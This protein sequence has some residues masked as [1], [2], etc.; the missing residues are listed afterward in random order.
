MA[1]LITTA[2]AKQAIRAA[3]YDTAD[4]AQIAS[5][6]SAVSDWIERHC[7]RQFNDADHV[8]FVKGNPL[9]SGLVLRQ[10]P[11]IHVTSVALPVEVMTVENSDGQSATVRVTDG[12]SLALTKTVDGATTATGAFAF[13]TYTSIEDVAGQINGTTG[14]SAT[15]TPGYEKYPSARLH[16]QQHG[17]SVIDGS[18]A[19][20]VAHFGE[21]PDYSIDADSGILRRDQGWPNERIRVS[22]N[23]GFAAIPEAIQEACAEW[24]AILFHVQAKDEAIS[25]TSTSSVTGESGDAEASNTTHRLWAEIPPRVLSLI[26]PFRKLSR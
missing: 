14:W 7:N 22:Y 6:V 21:I 16:Q 23:A 13:A 8:D 25:Q 15:V 26:R 12:T 17:A 19:R 3:A 11:I 20:I 18:V 1:D 24:V 5:L 4:D 10:Y 9:W 2:R